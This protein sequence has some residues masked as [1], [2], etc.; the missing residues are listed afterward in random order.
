MNLLRADRVAIGGKGAIAVA[1]G[2]DTE[3]RDPVG[4]GRQIGVEGVL[5]AEMGPNAPE[6]LSGVG[7]VVTQSV[8]GLFLDKAE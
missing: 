2:E 1:L 7:I 3:K 4:D 6:V 5:G 8:S